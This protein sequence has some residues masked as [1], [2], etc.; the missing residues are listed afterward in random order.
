MSDMA[1]PVNEEE[2]KDTSKLSNENI[3]SLEQ[4][5]HIVPA[6]DNDTLPQ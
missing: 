6:L 3:T 4:L 2:V 5:A 1:T